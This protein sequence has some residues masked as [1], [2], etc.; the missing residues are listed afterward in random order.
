MGKYKKYGKIEPTFEK[1]N[2]ISSDNSNNNNFNQ[3]KNSLNKKITINNKN[4]L[5]NLRNRNKIKKDEIGF[6]D[7]IWDILD[8][9]KY[10]FIMVKNFILPSGMSFKDFSLFIILEILY[11]GIIIYIINSVL[12]DLNKYFSIWTG[13]TNMYIYL[14]SYIQMIYIFICEG[15]LIFRFIHL[16]LFLFKK[17]NWLINLATCIIIILNIIS[18]S[19]LNGKIYTFFGNNNFLFLN[20]KIVKD[21]LVRENINL[22]INKDEDFE[23]YEY[24]FEI[25]SNSNLMEK[26]KTKIHNYKWKY[27]SITNHYIACK[28]LSL[29]NLTNVERSKLN[30]FY[31]CENVGDINTAPNY[32]VSSLYRQKRF[33]SHIKIAFFEMIIII[34]WNLYNNFSM[35][36][37]YNYFPFLKA[38]NKSNIYYQN[39]N[40]K[41]NYK[42][43][44]KNFYKKSNMN[45]AIIFKDINDK[46]VLERKFS[47]EE[48]ENEEDEEYIKNIE[49]EKEHFIKECKYWRIS[50]KRMK[51]YKKKR[52]KNRY[53]EEKINNKNKYF[54]DEILN[55]EYYENNI[56]DNDLEKSEE[57]EED[58]NDF[59][60][61]NKNEFNYNEEKF[62]EK[63]DDEENSKDNEDNIQNYIAN[64]NKIED[65][66][67]LYFKKIR[68]YQY[69]YKICDFLFGKFIK[70]VKKKIHDILLEVD[71]HLIDE[72]NDDN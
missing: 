39:I 33:F 26:I 68:D 48:E 23:N 37:I 43:N 62:E 15:L 59:F 50:K 71:K 2:K 17:L 18:I 27:D 72:D 34:L 65:F 25:K 13:L 19:E 20:N 28:N 60:N 32:C 16:K 55:Q 46:Q 52:K 64:K 12:F 24:C 30:I 11:Q 54:D 1:P 9:I 22:Y 45:T 38:N 10:F 56:D 58:N 70:M 63:D 61:I 29:I 47:E 49:D 69:I 53:K 14:S 35:H 21:N 6:N 3:G 66:G 51:S 67:K 42:N 44:A 31:N 41:N 5:S 4:E 7:I 36:L 40:R 57:E 8:S